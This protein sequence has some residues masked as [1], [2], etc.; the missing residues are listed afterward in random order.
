MPETHVSVIYHSVTGN[1]QALAR[2]A[3]EGAREA[4]A[5]VR[6]LPVQDAANEDLTWADVVLFGTPSRYGT[7]AAEV[8]Q[9]I[10][11]TGELWKA[12]K[13]AG[14]VYGAFVSSAS[15]HA[16]QESTLLGFAI[17]FTHWGGIIVPPGFTAPIQFQSGNPY[18][19]SHVAGAGG[20]PGPVA[21]EAARHQARRSVH[22]AASLAPRT[23][24]EPG[25]HVARSTLHGRAQSFT[26]HH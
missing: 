6:L 1:V 20:L 15:L 25:R 5:T 14:K 8:K 24:P 19:A 13:L 17:V 9:F 22:V 4:G 12:G 18:G 11:G 7:M 10:D 3:A 26:H 2:A 21:L 23:R 16:G